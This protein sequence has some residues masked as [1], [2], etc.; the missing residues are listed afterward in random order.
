[1]HVRRE[2]IRKSVLCNVM[3][4]VVASSKKKLWW[5]YRWESRIRAG[6]PIE[7]LI[8][9]E[10]RLAACAGEQQT[11]SLVAR[12][13]QK[14]GQGKFVMVVSLTEKQ[15]GIRP[16]RPPA[17]VRVR[18]FTSYFVFNRPGPLRDRLG[19]RGIAVSDHVGHSHLLGARWALLDLAQLALHIVEAALQ[20]VLAALR[21]L[22]AAD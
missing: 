21:L 8:F 15:R 18:R 7:F 5:W 3:Q 6:P 14:H 20:L 17:M 4:W 13:T 16:P 1:M 19:R 11:D 10:R 2:R 12:E 22:Q 9:E